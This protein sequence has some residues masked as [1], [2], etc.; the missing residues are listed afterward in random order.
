MKT[1]Q[2]TTLGILFCFI[3]LFY[4]NA[5]AQV[6]IGGNINIGIS[7]PE[8]I[9]RNP[10]PPVRRVPRVIKRKRRRVVKRRVHTCHNHCVCNVGS[11]GSI[12]NQF[13]GDIQNFEVIDVAIVNR[14][15]GI[16]E[17]TAYLNGGDEMF[18]AVINE[19]RN[20]YNYH[21]DCN[22]RNYQN[23]ILEVSYNNRILPLTSGS[24]SIQPK[25]QGNF[26]VV[27]N[28]HGIHGDNFHGSFSTI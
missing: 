18:F 22:S 4:N 23:R 5:N 7:L 6:R 11:L 21:Y 26:A 3:A 12:R 15:D 28:T 9:V 14:P 8:I 17:V 16:I 24:I 10:Q 25:Q 2:T 20:N 19:D 13:H 27:I 1:L